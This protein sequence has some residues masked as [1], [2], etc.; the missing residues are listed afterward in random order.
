[1]KDATTEHAHRES[2]HSAWTNADCPIA[3]AINIV[4][5]RSAF[6]MLREAFYGT[7]RFDDFA[8]GAEVSESIAAARLKEF[9]EAGLLERRPYQEP[10][11][12]T[13]YEYHLTEMGYDFYPVIAGLAQWGMKWPGPVPAVARLGITHKDCGAPISVELTC[14]NGHTVSDRE[15]ALNG[16]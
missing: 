2:P 16:E 12:R 9:V 6:L 11:S 3:R 8:R 1:M 7:T 14:T 4:G 13:R 15:I 5:N 10:G